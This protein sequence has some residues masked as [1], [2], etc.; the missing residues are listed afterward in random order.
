MFATSELILATN[1][2]GFNTTTSDIVQ[3]QGTK[4]LLI[5]QGKKKR[6]YRFSDRMAVEEIFD[7]V[8]SQLHLTFDYIAF[9]LL[10]SIIA[11]VGLAT[12]SAVTVVAAMIVDP[13]MGPI[14]GMTFGTT[15]R[16]RISSFFFFR[17]SRDA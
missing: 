4:P 10:A 6:Q 2:Y 16:G 3:L 9:T 14:L 1:N 17:Y 12:G 13:F 8:D 15:I 5:S 11:G 7:I